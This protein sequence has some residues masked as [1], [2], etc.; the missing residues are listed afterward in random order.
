MQDYRLNS[1]YGLCIAHLVQNL[2]LGRLRATCTV[3]VKRTRTK[4]R[5]KI[6]KKRGENRK[7]HKFYQT[8][9]VSQVWNPR[10]FACQEKSLPLHKLDISK[11]IW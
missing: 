1:K 5:K 10:L 4:E 11:Y 7:Q 6:E 2:A 3:G 9:T 8:E